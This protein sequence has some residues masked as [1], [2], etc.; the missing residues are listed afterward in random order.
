[1]TL[2][3]ID[4][5]EPRSQTRIQSVSRAVSLLL[6]VAD[7]PDGVAAKQ[8]ADRTGMPLPTAYHLL[9]TLWAE[10]LLTKDDDRRFRLGPVVGRL[11]EAYE[12]TSTV[13]AEFRR[14][15]QEVARETGE[16]VYLGVWRD[17]GVQVVDRV[18]GEHA[19]RVIGLDVGF[20]DDMHARASAKLFLAMA[21][22]DLRNE[23][24]DQ[25]HMRRLTPRTLTTRA[26]LLAEFDE[27][28]RTELAYDREEF[29]EGVTCVSVPITRNGAIEACITISVPTQR[30]ES[31]GADIIRI[32]RTAVSRF[33]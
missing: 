7:N 31:T 21:P 19:V 27:I 14:A 4:A 33:G 1:M 25:M 9:T 5:T 23:V 18:E 20:R 6:A 24:L 30:F 26:E 8:L 11:S 22:E 29:Q 15:L 32:L 16:T 13:P 3:E 10:G 28:R 17:R 2:S 12:R